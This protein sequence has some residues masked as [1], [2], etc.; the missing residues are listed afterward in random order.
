MASQW[1][2]T[3]LQGSSTQPKIQA[4]RVDGVQFQQRLQRSQSR[5]IVGLSFGSH[6]QVVVRR[7]NQRIHSKQLVGDLGHR[8]PVFGG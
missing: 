5:P 3:N 2:V 6:R 7:W 8:H 1:Q 4:C